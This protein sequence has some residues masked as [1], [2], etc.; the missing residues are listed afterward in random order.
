[1]YLTKLKVNDFL[2]TS[3]KKAY[4]TLFLVL[5]LYLNFNFLISRFSGTFPPGNRES[6]SV[7]NKI[8]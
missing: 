6:L 5:L 4:C 3:A 2:Q 7:E 8:R 1:M